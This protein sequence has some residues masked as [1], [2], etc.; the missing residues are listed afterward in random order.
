MLAKDDYGHRKMIVWRNLDEMEKIT[1]QVILR[2]IPK[3]QF[4]L[5]DQIDR[6]CGSVVANFIE[7]YY[8]GYNKEY[9]KFLKYSKRS[10]AEL[11]NW[12][13]RAFYKSFIP[14]DDFESFDKLTM[15]TI[16]LLNRLINALKK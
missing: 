6:A 10:V 12:V 9:I 1:Q 16:Y 4:S 2:K 7:G 3:N 8:S 15:R 11:Q 14:Q 5:V 13:R